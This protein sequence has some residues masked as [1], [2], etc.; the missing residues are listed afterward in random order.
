M[1]TQQGSLIRNLTRDELICMQFARSCSGFHLGR[2][3]LGLRERVSIIPLLPSH[4]HKEGDAGNSKE[5]AKNQGQD[6]AWRKEERDCL[7]E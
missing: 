7:R 2:W 3:G 4:L 5:E 6:V 1:S